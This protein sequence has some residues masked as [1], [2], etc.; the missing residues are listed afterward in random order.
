MT[1]QEKAFLLLEQLKALELKIESAS[2]MAVKPLIKEAAK[3]QR[4]F[5]AV[6]AMEVFSNG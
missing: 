4:Q 5:N 6:L 2:L 3:K 1:N